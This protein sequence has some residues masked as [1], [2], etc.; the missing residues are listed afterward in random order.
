M[1]LILNNE[2][3]SKLLTMELLVP[4]LEE[5]YIELYEGRGGNRRRSDIV[6]PTT[7]RD[8][9]LYAL[10]SMD[11]VIPKFGIGAVRINSDILTFPQ[12]GNEMRRV[13]MP[14]APG[15]RYVGLVL[16]FSTHNG[17]PLIICP[18]G[19]MQRM[20]VGGT[21]AVAAKYLSRKD[22]KVVTIIGSG[23]QAD[24]QLTALMTVRDIEEVRVFSPTPEN[25]EAFAVRMSAETGIPV[26][27]CAT[28]EEACKDADI[29]ACATNSVMPVFYRDWIEP[30]MHISTVRPASSE[31]ERKAWDDID[32][33]ALLDHDDNAEMV[34]THNVQV[35]EEKAGVGYAIEHDDWHASLPS[36][37][38]LITGE[39]EGRTDDEQVTCF[40]NN[41]GMGYQFAA[42][43]HVLYQQAKDSG[44]GHELPTD[45]FTEKEHP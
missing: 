13:K 17:E 24:A 12:V 31:V 10:K 22:S 38:Q 5:A 15:E 1:T 37:G 8:D 14:A 34:Y 32:V 28:G 3:I 39:R 42:A 25:R 23:W 20:R 36:L 44:M 45:W 29:V 41:L 30:G 2:E 26:R 21:N 11:G 9:G 6:T 27:A 18:D 35:G 7:Q 33:F 19:V 43:G 4:V 40:L 16:L